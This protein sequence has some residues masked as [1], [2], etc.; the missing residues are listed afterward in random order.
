[1]VILHPLEWDWQPGVNSKMLKVN[2]NNGSFNN[3]Y[4]LSYY[5]FISLSITNI[6]YLTF[7]T[8]GHVL[9]GKNSLVAEK[10][11]FFLYLGDAG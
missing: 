2:I 9:P 10:N 6:Q 1:M 7:F 4:L 3:C 11:L 5:L 8:F